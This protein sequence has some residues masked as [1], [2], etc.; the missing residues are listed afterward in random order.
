[1]AFLPYLSLYKAAAIILLSFLTNLAKLTLLS[2]SSGD[3]AVLK[4]P[5]GS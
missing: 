2:N 4:P 5:I 3:E 1:M